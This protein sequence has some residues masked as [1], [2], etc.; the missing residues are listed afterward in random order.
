MFLNLL[1]TFLH[2]ENE[3]FC[4]TIATMLNSRHARMGNVRRNIKI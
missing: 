3:Y 1:E 4:S 2:P